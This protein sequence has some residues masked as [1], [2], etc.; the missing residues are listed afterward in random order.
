[1]NWAEE[2]SRLRPIK[3][4]PPQKAI[5]LHAEFPA[6]PKFLDLLQEGVAPPLFVRPLPHKRSSQGGSR[7]PPHKFVGPLLHVVRDQLEQTI[8]DEALARNSPAHEE[9]SNFTHKEGPRV[10]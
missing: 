4:L 1:M 2:D 5:L 10:H 6:R 3:P 9:N 7:R 8:L